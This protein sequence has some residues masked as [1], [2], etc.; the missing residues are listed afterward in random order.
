M[1]AATAAARIV[2][3]LSVSTPTARPFSTRTRRTRV[4]SLMSTPWVTAAFAMAWVIAP[5]PPIAWPQTPFF[6]FTSP[7]L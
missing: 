5:I 4:E 6:P 3:P 1:P 2:S 7:K